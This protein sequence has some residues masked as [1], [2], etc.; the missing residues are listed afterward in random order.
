MPVVILA[1]W[2]YTN[3]IRQHL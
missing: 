1:R 3:D 2:G